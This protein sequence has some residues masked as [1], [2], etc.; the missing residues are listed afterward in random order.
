MPAEIDKTMTGNSYTDN[1]S[2]IINVFGSYQLQ[3]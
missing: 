3:T 2:P 1:L